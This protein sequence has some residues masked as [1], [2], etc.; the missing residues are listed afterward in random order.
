MTLSNPPLVGQERRADRGA[1]VVRGA[2]GKPGSGPRATRGLTPGGRQGQEHPSDAPMSQARWHGKRSGWPPSMSGLPLPR[3]SKPRT[4]LPSA[5]S[6]AAAALGRNRV[7]CATP[8]GATAWQA[9]AMPSELD[10]PE[11]LMGRFVMCGPLDAF[12]YVD[13]PVPDTRSL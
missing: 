5:H 10:R 13:Q 4:G 12:E 2:D 11:A 9:R 1:E 7:R 6:A 3:Q 8:A